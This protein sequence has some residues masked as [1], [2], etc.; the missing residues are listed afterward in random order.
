ML[1]SDYVG[2]EGDMVNEKPVLHAVLDD[3]G[4]PMTTGLIITRF[5]GLDKIEAL[6]K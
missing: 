3:R 5:D 2:E 1:M 4:V 6:Y